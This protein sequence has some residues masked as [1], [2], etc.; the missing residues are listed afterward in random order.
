MVKTNWTV[1]YIT[2]R[3]EEIKIKIGNFPQQNLRFYPENPRIYSIVTID[4]AEPSQEKIESTLKKREHVKQLVNSIVA[5]GGLTDPV[6][7]KDGTFDVL[8]GNSR[9][10]AYRILFQKDPIKWGMIKCRFLPKELDEDK[11]FALLGDYHIIGRQDWAPYE[12]AGY[13]Y[14]RY[15]KY[16]V[17]Y[18]KLASDLG[19][20]TSEV[21][22]L[23]EVYALMLEHKEYDIN[24]YSYYDVYH[25]SRK[26][27]K[28]RSKY[29][30]L[31]Q[32]IV[33]KIK[34]GEIKRAA[35]L[36]DEM[37][38]IARADKRIIKGLISGKYD[39][40]EAAEHA[41]SGG[42]GDHIYQK[43]KK[44]K[45]WIISEEVELEMLNLTKRVRAKT[46][47]ELGKIA[48]KTK[49][50]KTKVERSLQ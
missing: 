32:V 48:Q 27:L 30:I 5:N 45:Q 41:R 4:E 3:G 46:K 20:T 47:Y 35:D 37:P 7:V 50:L 39:F 38:L 16:G 43:I 29:P 25:R 26:I 18:A 2:L 42:A 40:Y 31:D 15:E 9:L 14:R 24:K 28:A 1:D 6:F 21:K 13:L 44:F 22:N 33:K 49:S 17:S 34:S 19:F 12:Q 8:E 23:I 36:R 10:A 11:V